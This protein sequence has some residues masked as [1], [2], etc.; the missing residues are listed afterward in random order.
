MFVRIHIGR[1]ALVALMRRVKFE[2]EKILESRCAIHNGHGAEQETRNGR[3]G[4]AAGVPIDRPLVLLV[5][6]DEAVDER[7]ECFAG[8]RKDECACRGVPVE[9]ETG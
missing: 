7:D 2:V 5:F 8:A 9:L 6:V 4:Q 1:R 3:G